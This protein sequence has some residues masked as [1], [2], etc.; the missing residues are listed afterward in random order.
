MKKIFFTLAIAALFA[1]TQLTGC[2][3]SAKKV[4]VAQDNVDKANLEL[5]QAVKDSILQFRT[6]SEVKITK[7]EK[8]IAE[9][10]SRIAN[11]KKENRAIYEQKLAEL[12]KRNSELK[13][14]L[15]DYKYEEQAKW[16]IFKADYNRD[17][18]ELGKSFDDL[19]IK[20]SK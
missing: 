13:M 8:G 18:D 12:E 4:E 2:R 6:T 9:F 3:S 11:E 17:M 10:K 1:G 16:E 19:T 7:Y 20:K 14:K 15:A 5:D